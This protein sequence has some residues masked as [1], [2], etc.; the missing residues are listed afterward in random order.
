MKLIELLKDIKYSKM[1]GSSD[2]EI[3]GISIDSRKIKKGDIFVAIKGFKLDGHNF[4]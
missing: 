3:S 2:T 1:S 4:I